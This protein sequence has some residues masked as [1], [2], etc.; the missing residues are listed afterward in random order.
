[1]KTKFL[2]IG[3]LFIGL[4]APLWGQP[5]A[6]GLLPTPGGL[7]QALQ[8]AVMSSLNLRSE[9]LPSRVDLAE[10]ALIARDQG[11]IGSC[12]SFATSNAL[13]LMR[14]MRDRL[15]VSNRSF[16][17]PSFLY[18]QVMI[19]NDQG[20]T[21]YDNL[22]LAKNA[23]IATVITFPYTQNTRLRP[24]TNAFREAQLYKISEWRMIQHDDVGAF[25]SFLAKGFPVLVSIKVYPNF[26]SYS[27]GIFSP[28]G[29][30]SGFHAVVITGY[31]DSAGGT[32]T[33]CN[34]W[35]EAW[36]GGKGRFKFSYRTLSTRDLL[37]VEAYVLVPAARNPAV[38]LFPS[39]VE[40]SRG[41]L[42][43][44]VIIQ[45][46]SVPNA[47]EYEVFRLDSTAPADPREEQYVSLG[48]T[49]GTVFEDSNIRQ[50]HRYFYLIRTHTRNISS[51]LSFPVEGWSSAI[52]NVPPG[53]PSGFRTVLQ[54]SAVVCSWD[55]VDNTD[56]YTVYSW[57]NN[58]WFKIGSATETT[59]I[60]TNPVSEGRPT[61]SYIV[62]AENRWGKSVPSN[63]SSVTLDDDSADDNGD[64]EDTGNERF[65]GR[66]YSFPIERFL[67][68]ERAF[69]T[70]FERG[71]REFE[72]RF[73]RLMQIF[74]Y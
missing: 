50:D 22:E 15:P 47:L 73:R 72:E 34:S 59:Y 13:T 45:W 46:Q 32:F 63:V 2:A 44:K 56:F 49:S 24:E 66:F 18:N 40:A 51:D 62:V 37:V 1:M 69:L 28:E 12:G 70:G 64:A 57:R 65:D 39:G 68:A 54:G 20:S 55:H 6:T 61:I 11:L 19:G 36:G 33:A 21:Y 8:P 53:P 31:D 25:K 35:G 67:E 26:Y 38:P 71:A 29:S 27:G 42:R 60:N 52:P 9:V 10:G 58:D 30:P 74:L 23:G 16:H 43:D 48:V 4:S 14:R 5:R 3:F 7:R 41:S 17:S